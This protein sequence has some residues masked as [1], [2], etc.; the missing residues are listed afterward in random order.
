MTSKE[1]VRTRGE[2]GDRHQQ[3]EDTYRGT[4]ARGG[5][6]RAAPRPRCSSWAEKTTLPASWGNRTGRGRRRWERRGGDW[7]SGSRCLAPPPSSSVFSS[8]Y[9]YSWSGG[10]SGGERGT[11]RLGAGENSGFGRGEKAACPGCGTGAVA[12]QDIRGNTTQHRH[13]YH[14]GVRLGLAGWQAARRSL[15]LLLRLLHS[16]SSP[17]RFPPAS[18]FSSGGGGTSQ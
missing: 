4:G 8:G 9:L 10:G 2:G 11:R 18:R 1:T 16:P 3:E 17:S 7:N 12:T 14:S 6:S 13:P 15:S 5:R